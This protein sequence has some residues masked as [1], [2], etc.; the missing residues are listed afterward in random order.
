MMGTTFWPPFDE[1]RTDDGA[2]ITIQRTLEASELIQLQI[3]WT[4]FDSDLVAK[5]ESLEALVRQHGRSFALAVDWLNTQR[6]NVRNAEDA[7]WSF[8]DTDTADRFVA[9][10]EK[11]T[12]RF[13]PEFLLVGVEVNFYALTDPPGFRSFVR[14]FVDLKRRLR[15]ISPETVVLVSFQY[16][17]MQGH[18][19]FGEERG[20]IPPHFE[21]ISRFGDVLDTL[22]LSTYPSFLF[23]LPDDIPP[24]YF[25]PIIALGKPI[26]IS[27]TSWQTQGSGSAAAQDAYLRWILERA[28]DSRVSALIW[29]SS[30]DTLD[31]QH[32]LSDFRLIHG[33][34]AWFGSLGLWDISGRPKAGAIRWQQAMRERYQRRG[35]RQSGP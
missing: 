7:P 22:G 29:T 19:V 14:I 33:V 8:A 16:E 35:N 4:P 13:K 11:A 1:T 6:S 26:V 25:D 10:V 9:S 21:V 27:E 12:A 20:Y 32:G 31:A 15:L 2:E 23:A 17:L 18:H 34:P 28:A 3:P 5:A 24:T 30:C